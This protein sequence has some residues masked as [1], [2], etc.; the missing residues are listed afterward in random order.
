MTPEQTDAFRA[1]A[2]K[3]LAL[4]REGIRLRPEALAWARR[5]L[6]QQP[7]KTNA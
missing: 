4:H 3:L 6:N 7:E 1:H 5:I 2:E